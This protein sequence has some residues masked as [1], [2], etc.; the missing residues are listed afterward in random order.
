MNFGS[1]GEMPPSTRVSLGLIECTASPAHFTILAKM[2]QSLS[3]SKSQCD[4]LFGS[5]HNFIASTTRVPPG[6][7]ADQHLLFRMVD[8]VKA[9][10]PEHCLRARKI[11][12]P[13]VRVV[14]RVLVLHEIHQRVAI[15]FKHVAV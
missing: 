2:L 4:R 10:A 7:P 6:Y 9:G 12:D 14:I 11:R 13:P 1:M 5:F 15:L 8:D 3:I